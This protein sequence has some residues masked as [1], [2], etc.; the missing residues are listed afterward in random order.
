MTDTFMPKPAD[1]KEK[2]YIIDAAGL[3][4]GRI[5]SRV[6]YILR[7]KNS[8]DYTPHVA[9]KHHVIVINCDQIVLT[10]RKAEKKYYYT[11]SKYVGGLKKTQY[12]KMMAE[13]SD[14]ALYV[15]IKGML[16]NTSMGRNMLTCIRLY[17]GAE[18]K[19]AAQ[20]PESVSI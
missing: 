18:H 20:M 4:L 5:A 15:A 17:K 10:G 7:G 2:W 14:L 1:V 6:A 12:S 13:K 19:H 11:H 16:P 9:P 8:V 3:P